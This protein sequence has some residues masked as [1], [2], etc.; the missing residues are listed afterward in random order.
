VKQSTAQR[1]AANQAR[2]ERAMRALDQKI[3]ARLMYG[4]ESPQFKSWEA[5][6]FFRLRQWYQNRGNA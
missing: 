3:R 6:H 2:W 4:G 5:V 1:N